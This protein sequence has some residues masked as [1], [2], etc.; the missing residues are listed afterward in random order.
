VFLIEPTETPY[1]LRWRMF[2]VPV[3]VHP[4]FWLMSV[5]L[6]WSKYVAHGLDY[7]ALWVGCVFVSI[8]LHEFGHVLMGGLFGSQGYIVLYSFGGLAVGS[9]QL[10]RRWQRVLVSLAGPGIQLLLAGALFALAVLLPAEQGPEDWAPYARE[11]FSDLIWINFF[12][13]LLNLLPVYPLD[14]GQVSREVCQAVAPQGGTAFSLGLSLVVAGGLALHCFL[15]GRS[16]LPLPFLGG[17][18]TGILFAMLAAGSLQG[19]MMESERRRS[20]ERSDDELPWER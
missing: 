17:T 10:A 11:V 8:L 7:L 4:M 9:N 5:L 16:P 15:G 13:A 19:L 18:Y 14:G 20:Y 6:G 3:R 12:W 1:D 2:G